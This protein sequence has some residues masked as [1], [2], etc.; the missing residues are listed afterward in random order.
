MSFKDE[1][2][3]R[4]ALKQAQIAFEADE[5]PVGSVLVKDGKILA[6]VHN[7]RESLNDPTAHAE[8][9]VLREASQKLSSWRLDDSTLYVTLEPCPMCAGAIVLARVKRL[10][11]GAFDPKS[12]AAGTLMNLLND[13]RLNHQVEIC[14]GVLE[15]ESKRLLRA[16]FYG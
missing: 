11:F 12:G 5:V 7:Q 4:E 16:F 3:M 14:G 9:L 8:I 6:C 1:Y 2:F 15:E 13:N 10:V